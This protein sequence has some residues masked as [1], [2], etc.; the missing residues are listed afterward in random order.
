MRKLFILLGIIAIACCLC[1]CHRIGSFSIS[2]HTYADANKYSV[3]SFSYRSSDVERIC[4]E[5]ISGDV[6]VV[7]STNRTLNVSETEKGL[8]DD[9]KMHWYMVE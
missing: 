4:L 8:S 7:Q 6:T 5:Y 9:Q 2:G 3:G 1:S